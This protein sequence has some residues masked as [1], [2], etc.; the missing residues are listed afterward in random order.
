MGITETE[1]MP[2]LVVE[3]FGQ[4]AGKVKIG[5]EFSKPNNEL[6]P[7]LKIYRHPARENGC[8]PLGQ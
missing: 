5:K 1:L 3:G 7:S 4:G 2:N 8:V 6:V